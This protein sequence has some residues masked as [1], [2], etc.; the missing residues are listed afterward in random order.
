MPA[1][2]TIGKNVTIFDPVQLGFPSREHLGK[3]DWPGVVIGDDCVIRSG[4][5]IYSDVVFGN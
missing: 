4:S 2:N 5:V 1:Q 3:E